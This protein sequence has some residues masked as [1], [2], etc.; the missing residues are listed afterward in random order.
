MMPDSAGKFAFRLFDIGNKTQYAVEAN[1]VRSPTFTLD[2]ANL[3]VRED[4]RPAVPLSRRI[5]SSS[6]RTSTAPATSRRSRA[7]WSASRVAPTMPTAGGRVIVEGGD[8]LKLVPTGDGQL[9]AMLRVDKPGFYKVELEGPNGKMVTGS[10]NYTIDVLPDRPPTMRFTKPGRDQKVLSVDEVYTEVARR[11]R[12]RRLEG[13]SRLLGERRRRKKRCRLHDGTRALKDISAGY[14]F[15]LEGMKL[16]PGDVVSY[17]ARATDNNPVSGV[18]TASTDIYFLNVRPYEQDY[19]QGSRA[20][21]AVAAA[22]ASRTTP[23]SSRSSS[24]TSS[25]ATFKTARDSATT[26][27]K[28]LDENLATL[29]LSQ[30]RLREQANQ[31]AKRLIERGIA[32]SD[33]NWKRIAE[34]LAKAGAQM[35]TAEKKLGGGSPNAAL[36][37]EQRALQQ[38]QRAEAVFRD[39]QVSDGSAAGRRRWRRRQL[40]RTPRISPTSSSC[41]KTRCAISTRRCSADS[42][43]SGQQQ[44]SD[45]QVDETAEKLRQLAARQQQENDRARAKADSLGRMGQSGSQGGQGQRD[46]AQQAEEEARKLERLAREQS[47]QRPRRC[48]APSAGCGERRCVARRRTARREPAT[49]SR[50]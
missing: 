18:Q 19:R 27:K 5:R 49:R 10:L 32:A 46:L 28:T 41:R 6:R 34:M 9:M 29:R 25:P 37:P 45:N 47:N 3:A 35:D 14:T 13:R 33:S 12:L 17:Y 40:D 11:R 7:R 39:I 16:E 42:S 50:R 30:Q 31:L 48:G 8:T 36:G 21:A 1:G 23:A 20:A 26:D 44:Q 38:L 22:A 43:S 4:D 15:M 24:A 2:V